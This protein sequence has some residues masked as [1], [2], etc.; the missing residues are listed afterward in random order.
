MNK[1]KHTLK[2]KQQMYDRFSS[3]MESAC[4]PCIASII[5][6]NN[7]SV[8]D[9]FITEA[10]VPEIWEYLNKVTPELA[11]KQFNR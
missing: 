4:Y 6:Q 7:L 11:A 8:S 3:K 5:Q 2:E 1:V 10:I 9:E